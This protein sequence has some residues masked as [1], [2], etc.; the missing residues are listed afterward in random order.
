MELTPP[1]TSEQP[2]PLTPKLKLLAYGN[3]IIGPLLVLI[4]A[5]V[6]YRAVEYLRRSGAPEGFPELLYINL[7]IYFF[8]GLILVGGGIDLYR[9]R[10]SGWVWSFVA[11]SS[12]ILAAFAVRSVLYMMKGLLQSGVYQL[13]TGQEEFQYEIS[14]GA[15][16]ALSPIYAIVMLVILF[17]PETRAWARGGSATIGAASPD[18]ATPLP[19]NVTAKPTNGLAIAS[20]VCSMIPMM[21]LTQI[22]GITLGIIALRK[23]KKSEGAIGG[24]GFAIAGIV[25][26][27]LI[28]L[29]MMGIIALILIPE[30][31][32][33]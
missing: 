10:R 29:F 6:I 28:L 7:G 20:F 26:S 12:C 17:L 13:R 1:T 8:V 15:L 30:I 2:P 27:S 24:K 21:L 14:F 33:S 23:I 3:L 31:S 9:N 16:P 18:V 11:A 25:I 32:R 22:A 19:S 5:V 4:N